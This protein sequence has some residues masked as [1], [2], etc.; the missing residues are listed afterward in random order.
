MYNRPPVDYHWDE[1]HNCPHMTAKH[2]ITEAEVEEVLFGEHLQRPGR[3]DS[4]IAIGQT[5]DGRWL[6][7][8]YADSDS[9]DGGVFVI[10]AYDLSEQ[11]KSAA[12]KRLDRK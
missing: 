3:E 5:D 4:A 12:R 9:I 6:K 10:T 11:E 8:I 1:E 7:I 2:G